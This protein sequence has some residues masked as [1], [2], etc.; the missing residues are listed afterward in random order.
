MPSSKRI[1][2]LDDNVEFAQTAALLLKLMGWEAVTETN[3]GKAIR[4]VLDEPFDLLLTDYQMPGLDGCQVAHILRTMGSL[5]PVILCTAETQAFD[6]D[7]LRL[8]GI[9]GVLRKPFD[10]REFEDSFNKLYSLAL[11]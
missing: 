7:D 1:L 3:P 10:K 11:N 4:R 6:P 2:V 8:V 5:I 9:L